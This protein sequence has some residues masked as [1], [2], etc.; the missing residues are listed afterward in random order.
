MRKARAHG[1]EH[2]GHEDRNEHKEYKQL[3][4]Q[5]TTLTRKVD[6]IMA[7]IGD[8]T[9]LLSSI[10]ADVDVIAAHETGEPGSVVSQAQLDS[11]VAQAQALKDKTAAVIA[12]F[13]TA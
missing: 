10:S 12:S 5:L 2:E 6:E 8:L 11:A 13:P 4:R 7:A 1:D 9:T 3:H